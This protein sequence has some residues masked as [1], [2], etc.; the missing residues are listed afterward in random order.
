MEEDKKKKIMIAIIV[1]CIVLAV[2]ITFATREKQETQSDTGEQFLC[3][4][5]DCGAIF[6]LSRGEFADKMRMI[7]RENPMTTREAVRI[8]CPECSQKTAG[9]ALKCPS[10]GNVFVP[11]Q[12]LDTATDK[13]PKCGYSRIEEGMNAAKE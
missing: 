4:N 6:T 8:E 3:L 13:C 5:K 11:K 1:S 2:V 7:M 10:C 9:I 12:A